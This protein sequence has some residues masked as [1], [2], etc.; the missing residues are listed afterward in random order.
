MIKAGFLKTIV[1]LLI[2]TA[3]I[4]SYREVLSWGLF[5]LFSDTEYS[6]E[7]MSRV[8]GFD[9]DRDILYLPPLHDKDMF[10]AAGDLSICRKK[11][12]RR[13]IYLYLTTGREYLKR[14]IERSHLHE[15]AVRGVFKNNPDIPED[16]A[17][18]PLL[19]SGF[20][21]RALS[22][23][24]AVGLW[25][26]VDNTARPLGLQ[27]NRWLDERR[28][29]EKSTEAAIR[30]LRTLRKLFPNWEL[31]LAAYNGG[32]GYVKRAMIKTGTGDFWALRES[33]RLREETGDYVPKY[34]ALLLIYKNQ[35]LFGISDEIA[36]PPCCETEYFTLAHPAD[37]RDVSRLSG[38]PLNTIRTLNPELNA[39]VTPPAE[40]NYRLRLPAD[41]KKR[42][43]ENA[44]ELYK[45]KISGVGEYRVRK[46]DTLTRIALLHKKK[47]NT[48]SGL[49][50]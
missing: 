26:F 11:E 30:H 43:T 20:D 9:P 50:E 18:L 22:R 38:V 29:V 2:F 47:L 10:R 24:R 39:T 45:K 12:V 21:P 6:A 44:G 3:V 1:F 23:S 48:S 17:L 31:A 40:K 36:V 4:G 14:G 19:E 7:G 34:L 49:T 37:L 35:R 28:S 16:I 15:N 46:G 13:Q 27:N 32:A 5:N 41:G 33:G 8:D 25:Q 42:L